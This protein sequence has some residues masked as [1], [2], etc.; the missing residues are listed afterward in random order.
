[1][2]LISQEFGILVF[3]VL[4]ILAIVVACW[5]EKY[6]VYDKGTFHIFVSVFCS[7][8]V[9]ITFLFYY[10][11]LA[12]QNQEQ[13]LETVQELSRINVSMLDNMLNSINEMSTIIPNFI[14]SLNPLNVYCP[15][16]TTGCISE[17]PINPKTVTARSTLSQ[18]IFS[19][20]QDVILSNKIKHFD[21]VSYISNFLQKANSQQLYEEW[22]LNKINFMQSTQI[23]GDLLFEYGLKIIN[24][25]PEEYQQTAS[26]LSLDPRYTSL[27]HDY[28]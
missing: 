8:G 3:L 6:E 28:I 11:L 2:A 22:K 13:Q 20:W 5:Y 12:L 17:D 24:Q 26:R 16:G 27:K 1:M 25:T 4:V 10:N 21:P 7:I 9:I 14:V 18:Q 19:H 15:T 23:F